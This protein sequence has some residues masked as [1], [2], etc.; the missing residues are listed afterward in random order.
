MANKEAYVCKM[1]AA[2]NSKDIPQESTNIGRRNITNSALCDGMNGLVISI[3][4]QFVRGFSGMQL[5]G[6]ISE[7]I[8]DSRERARTALESLDVHLP[9]Q[10]LVMS[11]TPAEVKKSGAQFDLA[12]AVNLLQLMSKKTLP[13]SLQA[14]RYIFVAGLSL[15]GD[16]LGVKGIINYALAAVAAG[17]HGMVVACANLSDLST[18]KSLPN[19]RFDDLEVVAFSHLREVKSW[20]AGAGEGLSVSCNQDKAKHELQLP[21]P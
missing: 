12:I 19:T 21:R 11:I 8:R 17:F 5:V 13:S 7:S 15:A 2:E 9:P 6:N 4:S 10:K 20:L 3:E 18:V 14:E 16:L 1:S